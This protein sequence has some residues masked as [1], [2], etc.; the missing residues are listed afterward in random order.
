MISN[1]GGEIVH[2]ELIL[3]DLTRAPKPDGYTIGYGDELDIVFLYNNDLSKPGIKVRPD[4]RLS[5]P[6]VGEIEVAG[7]TVSELE[8][9]LTRRFSEIIRDPDITVI[10]SRFQPQLVYVMGE[11]KDPG[12]YPFE[13]GATLLQAL[14]LCN[15]PT[16]DAKKSDV[17]VIR[18]VAPD[19]IVGIQIKLNQLLEGDRFDLDIPLEPFDIVLVPKSRISKVKDFVESLHSIL[20]KPAD[21]YMKGWDLANVKILFDWY[22]RSGQKL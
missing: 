18:R 13:K 16:K 5:Y 12:G 3:E 6:Y 20:S 9:I 22:R 21:L 15:G 10:V 1:R 2:G 4:G 14:A 19:H 8:G 7:M 17:L 11:V